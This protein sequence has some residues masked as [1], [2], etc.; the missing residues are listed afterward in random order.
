MLP[1]FESDSRPIRCFTTNKFQFPQHLHQSIE[2]ISCRRGVVSI[3]IE[4]TVYVLQSGDIAFVFP[5]TIHSYLETA[6]NTGQDIDCLI[7]IAAP[8]Y[9]SSFSRLL[10]LNRP[11]YPVLPAAVVHP[12][13]RYS[14]EG[15]YQEAHE[16][17]GRD[18]TE[19][20]YR[21]FMEL[22][23]SRA[24]S[25]L[26]LLP[27]R[28]LGQQDLV[29]QIMSYVQVHFQEK[30]SLEILAADLNVSKYYLSHTFSEKLKMSFPAYLNE[31]RLN[32]ALEKIHGGAVNI[33][34][35]WQDSGFES[36]RTFNRVFLNRTGMTPRD[37]IHHKRNAS[38]PV[39]SMP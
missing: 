15:L 39:S 37:F 20:V 32:H 13:I 16:G 34:E 19:Y 6:D 35:I 11:A 5:N 9:F 1:F 4:D 26:I 22:L 29:H 24:L 8:Q 31:F 3:Y 25:A 23:L 33:T 30:L 14:L 12:D 18:Y 2:I 27:A 36:Q 17:A 28:A 10:A 21:G 38:L 7:L